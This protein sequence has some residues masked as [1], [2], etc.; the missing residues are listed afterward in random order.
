MN[1]SYLIAIAKK[2]GDG[3]V[4]AMVKRVVKEDL[5]I[6]VAP[7]GGLIYPHKAPQWDGYHHYKQMRIW[8]DDTHWRNL[9]IRY[10]FGDSSN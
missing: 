6:T 10:N 7:N 1:L 5:S 3:A 8:G 4:V 2:G 9:Q